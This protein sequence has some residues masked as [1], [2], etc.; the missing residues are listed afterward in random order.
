MNKE[1]HGADEQVQQVVEE[2]H[3][4]DHGTVASRERAAVAHKAHEKDD[5]IADLTTTTGEVR[6]HGPRGQREPAL[7]GSGKPA[8]EI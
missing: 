4:Q 5:F 7:T 6:G 8:M 2:L 1:A 3:V